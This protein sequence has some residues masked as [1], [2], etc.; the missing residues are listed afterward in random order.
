MHLGNPPLM[1]V[2]HSDLTLEVY[3]IQL[4]RLYFSLDCLLYKLCDR[5]VVLEYLFDEHFLA[6]PELRQPLE[7]WVR[8]VIGEKG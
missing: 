2:L 6:L 3:L 1:I 4:V 5:L 7:Q 8:E